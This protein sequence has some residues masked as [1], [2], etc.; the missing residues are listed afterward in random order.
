MTEETKGLDEAL[1]RLVDRGVLDDGQAAAVRAEVGAGASRGPDLAELLAAAG[2]VLVLGAAVTLA[3]QLWDRLLPGAQLGILA[4]AALLLWAAG[5]WAAGRFTRGEDETAESPGLG[6]SGWLTGVLWL[7]STGATFGALWVAIEDLL[8]LS[9]EWGG[10]LLAVLTTVQALLLWLARRRGLQHVAL[11]IGVLA[12]VIT[13][14]GLI[15]HIEDEIYGLAIWGAGLAWGLLTWGGVAGPRRS[16]YAL[17]ALAAFGG[18]EVLF[19][20]Y[21]AAGLALGLA[22]SIAALALARPL[23]QAVLAGLGAAGLA[24]LVPQGLDHWFPDSIGAPASVFI[25]GVL[26]LAGALYT[27]RTARAVDAEPEESQ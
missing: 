13:G 12:V 17:A 1:A 19:F 26:I 22:S 16:G 4:L 11:F 8:G 27:L 23:D 20:G 5:R 15:P 7:A 14:I 3:A 24:V 18:S 9:E 25:A 6:T 21:A 10:F 2:G